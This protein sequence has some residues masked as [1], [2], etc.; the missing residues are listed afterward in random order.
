MSEGVKMFTLN[1]GSQ[2]SSRV[3]LQLTRAP[4]QIIIRLTGGFG[5]MEEDDGHRAVDLIAKALADF[6]GALIFGGTRI[7]RLSDPLSVVPTLGEIP[8]RIRQTSPRARILGIVPRLSDFC[9]I[10]GLGL[11]LDRREDLDQVTII[12]PD[13][14]TC[15]QVQPHV[16]GKSKWDAEWIESMRIIDELV[17]EAGWRQ[18]LLCYNGGNVTK[19][20]ILAWAE[21]QWPVLL[22]A[23]SGRITHE[24]ATTSEWKP[25]LQRHPNIHVVPHE[26]D[27]IKEAV[28]SLTERKAYL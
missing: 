16:D 6:E 10:P 21:R 27:A 17:S 3:A 22:I 25:F 14:D 23:D 18:L 8:Y 5:L 26:H 7:V 15:L 19:T 11:V 2:T 9:L 12:H 20:E 1:E 4:Q 24:I 28:A 13:Q